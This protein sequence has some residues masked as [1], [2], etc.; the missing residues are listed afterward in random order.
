VFGIY[1]TLLA[2]AVLVDH[3]WS[4]PGAGGVAVFSFFC[5]SGF[6]MTLLMTGP[7]RGRPFAFYLNRVLRLYPMYLATGALTLLVAS[8]I[9]LQTLITIP[10]D[11]I[12]FARQL[13]YVVRIED[14]GIVPTGWAVTNELVFY[15]LIGLG[16]SRNLKF[17]AIWLACSAIL[18]TIISARYGMWLLSLYFPWWSPALPFAFG[19]LLAHLARRFPAPKPM[20]AAAALIGSAAL[21]FGLMALAVAFKAR[22][23]RETGLM[24][25][26]YA[27][28]IP[29]AVAI[30]VLYRIGSPAWRTVDDW[31]GRLS[32]PM[33]LMQF[34]AAECVLAGWFVSF[35]PLGQFT[36]VLLVTVAL[37]AIAVMLIDVPIE[38]IRRRV[39]DGSAPAAPLA[40]PASREAVGMKDA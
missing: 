40:W 26:L 20:V 19:A 37:A 1:R 31:V 14:P 9:P 39:R 12:S 30:L 5:L 13:F 16:V 22:G 24:L 29:T 35:G 33:Y 7:Y 8:A 2:T 38:K 18:V 23:G 21:T 17:T 25:C 6:L 36:S 15:I 32:Y 10:G 3:F 11:A 34:V 28:L 4:A 27:S